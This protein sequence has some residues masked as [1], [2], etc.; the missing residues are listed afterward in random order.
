MKAKN[1]IERRKF[2]VFEE[3]EFFCVGL[4]ETFDFGMS[5]L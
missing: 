1:N 4:G 3:A 5:L 2:E